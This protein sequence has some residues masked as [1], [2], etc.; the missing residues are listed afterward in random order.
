MTDRDGARRP[1]LLGAKTVETSLGL[2][3]LVFSVSGGGQSQGQTAVSKNLCWRTAVSYFFY[4]FRVNALYCPRI[5]GL[6]F[7][8]L[9]IDYQLYSCCQYIRGIA[10]VV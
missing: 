9:F 4:P 10:C 2:D 6:R 8:D 1:V 5:L 3:I 7:S